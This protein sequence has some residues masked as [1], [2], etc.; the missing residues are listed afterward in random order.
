VKSS[1][2]V[3]D[4][5]WQVHSLGKTQSP[6]THGNAVVQTNSVWLTQLTDVAARQQIHALEALS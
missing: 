5:S 2:Y 1:T 6:Q 4:D 3:A